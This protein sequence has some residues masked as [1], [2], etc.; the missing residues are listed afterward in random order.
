MAA[1]P[2]RRHSTYRKGKRRAAIK[3][4]FLS[5]VNKKKA[6]FLSK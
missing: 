6:S 1:Q 4:K 3:L 5:I 2:K